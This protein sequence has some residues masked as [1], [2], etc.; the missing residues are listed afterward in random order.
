MRSCLSLLDSKKQRERER[1]RFSILHFW[2][3]V[4]VKEEEEE[5]SQDGVQSLA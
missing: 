4:T 3:P 2:Q 1:E 5:A